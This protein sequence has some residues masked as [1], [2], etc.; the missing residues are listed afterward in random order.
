MREYEDLN[1][2][3]CFPLYSYLYKLVGI[4]IYIWV[5]N[6][7]PT[8]NCFIQ[9]SYVVWGHLSCM[10]LTEAEDSGLLILSLLQLSTSAN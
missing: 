4:Y 9:K 2:V 1:Y 8:I 3:I 6:E 7:Y 10:E 5:R